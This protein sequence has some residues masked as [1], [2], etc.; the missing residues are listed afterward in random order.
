LH[1]LKLLPGDYSKENVTHIESVTMRTVQNWVR[2]WN[3]VGP[4][5][6]QTGKRKGD[7]S[8]IPLA[9]HQSLCD[10]L[11]YPEQADQT[12]WTIRKLHGYLNDNL[13]L[14]LG[15]STLTR[16]FRQKGFCLKVPRFWPYERD[17]ELREAFCRS[18]AELLSVPTIEVWFCD[19]TGLTGD[20]V[21]TIAGRTR[22]IGFVS[23]I[24]GCIFV[25]KSSARF[26]PPVVAWFPWFCLGVDKEAFQIFLD[27][28]AWQTKGGKEML[29]LDDASWRKAK[30]LNWHHLQPEY[31]PPYSPDLNPIEESWLYLKEHYFNNWIAKD[32][33]ELQDRV[34]WSIQQLLKEPERI[35]SV[36]SFEKTFQP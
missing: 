19:E 30:S 15:Y 18:M 2:L 13:Q 16:F 10:L 8:K 31:L 27:E 26:I 21:P 36:T 29:V 3:E 20:R 17:E 14:K 33:E 24:W 25:R 6:M 1:A 5:A 35:K 7:H 28:L 11:R 12:H 32:H 9:L 34:V 4:D 22:R 23:N